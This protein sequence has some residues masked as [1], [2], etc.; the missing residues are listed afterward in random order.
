MLG[1]SDWGNVLEF[2]DVN[3]A[4]DAFWS[5]YSDLFQLNFP[6]KKLRFNKNIHC[7]KPFMSQGLLKSCV[8]K[9]NA[10]RPIATFSGKIFK[11]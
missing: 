6:L 9:K 2:D 7:Q 5:T 1:G 11:V 4:Y 10:N 8:T 3:V